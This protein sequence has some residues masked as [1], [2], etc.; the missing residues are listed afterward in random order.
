[1]SVTALK[2]TRQSV[3]ITFWRGSCGLRCEV[4]TNGLEKRGGHWRARK[5]PIHHVTVYRIGVG[6]V[7]RFHF[8]AAAITSRSLATRVNRYLKS[9]A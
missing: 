9:A 4:L 8:A 2:Q 5:T 7:G 3:N 6:E 1:M